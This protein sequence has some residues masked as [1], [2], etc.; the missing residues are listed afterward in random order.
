MV[1]VSV[2]PK[3]IF[4]AN[5]QF[6]ITELILKRLCVGIEAMQS[7]VILQPVK[8]LLLKVVLQEVAE[9][10]IKDRIIAQSET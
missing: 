5:S 6:N 7:H 1:N 8:L 10:I 3:L 9:F 2:Q 4:I